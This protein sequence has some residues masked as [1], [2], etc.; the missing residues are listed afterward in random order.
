MKRYANK[1]DLVDGLNS[2]GPFITYIHICM[3]L[4]LTPS[5]YSERYAYIKNYTEESVYIERIRYNNSF[6]EENVQEPEHAFK[7]A[8]SYSCMSSLKLFFHS[9]LLEVGF[10]ALLKKN[11][12]I[13]KYRSTKKLN[14]GKTDLV[15]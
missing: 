1:L 6:L 11:S 15:G 13:S 5:P 12:V 8:A 10:L 7:T 9:N 3:Y 2:N 4:I 14:V